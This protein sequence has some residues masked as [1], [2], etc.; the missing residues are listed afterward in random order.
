MNHAIL[1]GYWVSL[2]LAA[3]RG[4]N[5]GFRRVKGAFGTLRQLRGT[6]SPKRGSKRHRPVPDPSTTTSLS[7]T[8]VNID[9]V[10]VC[11]GLLFAESRERPG[12]DGSSHCVVYFVCLQN[13]VKK[14]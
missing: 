6:E 3:A 12:Q 8:I 9:V 13:F 14:G 10:T 5:K 2:R 1:H 11:D 7:T 4:K